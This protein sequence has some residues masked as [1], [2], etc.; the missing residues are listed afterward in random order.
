MVS[1]TIKQRIIR[2]GGRGLRSTPLS[3]MVRGFFR[4]R[5]NII[6]YHAVWPANDKRAKLFGGMDL[7]QFARDLKILSR[8][9]QF[10][11]L[12][13]L[14]Q[15]NKDADRPCLVVTFDDGFD[16]TAGGA[17]DVMDELGVQATV[18]VNTASVNYQQLMWQHRFSAIRHLRGDEVFIK[19]FNQLQDKLANKDRLNQAGEQIYITHNWP[20]DKKDEYVDELWQSCNMPP[21]DDM[22]NEEH[23]YFDWDG[24]HKWIE[25]GHNVGCH[26][27]TH[28]FCSSLDDELIKNELISPA[29]ELKER[30]KLTTL[31]F[32]YPFGERLS[33]EHEQA[34]IKQGIFTCLLGTSDVF[35]L[36]D[37][38]PNI[39]V[40]VEAEAG[41]DQE[42]FGKAV[43]RA[44]KRNFSDSTK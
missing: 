43:I 17:T 6:F 22:L 25:R 31:S 33:P 18:F 5:A 13:T 24:L 4:R 12:D 37:N 20:M 28:P 29:T 38:D 23:P 14:L 9:F 26:T 36:L 19:Q 8:R 7:D 1:E 35:S 15:G 16:L 32:A 42:V 40:R 41:I 10:V 34:I 27:H 3:W 44:I 2:W 39:M 30:L 11:S 21:M